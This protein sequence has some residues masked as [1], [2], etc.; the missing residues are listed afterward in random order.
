MAGLGRGTAIPQAGHCIATPGLGRGLD[1]PNRR[2]QREPLS[3]AIPVAQ[4]PQ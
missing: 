4:T 1:P 2:P 3:S